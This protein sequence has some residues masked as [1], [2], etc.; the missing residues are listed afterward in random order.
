LIKAIK[1]LAG[2]WVIALA[3]TTSA[4]AQY[5]TGSNIPFGQNRVQYNE[6]YWQSFNFERF[7]VF[8]YADGKNHAI[9][10]AKSA[11]YNLKELEGLLDFELSDKIEIL[12]F[13]SQSQ[14][15]QSNI[16]LTNDNNTNIGGVTKII[17]SKIFVY[18]EGD[19]AT[20]DDQIRAGVSEVLLNQMMYGGSWKDVLKNNTLLSLPDW[21]LKG[22]ISYASKGWNTEIDNRVKDGILTD[23]FVNFNA[24]EGRDA[25]LAGHSIWNYIAEVY[26]EN[27]IPNVMYM[28]RVS[29]SVESGFLFVLGTPLK[30]LMNDY[31]NYYKRKYE[32]DEKFRNN[33]GG[34][35]IQIKTKKRYVY[36]D[37]SLSPDG[38]HASF[39]TN[40]RG[41]YKVWV[42]TIADKKMRRIHKGG[43]DLN[44]IV[45][46]TFPV[47]TWHPTSKVLTYFV[48]KKG[49]VVINIYSIE[50]KKTTRRPLLRLNKV[51][52]AEYSDD[53]KFIVLS[54]AKN[55]QTDLFL[56]KITGN[57][58][59]QLR[60][61]FTMTCIPVSLIIQPEL[62]FLP[63][64]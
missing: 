24:L 53:G 40:E 43:L 38:K 2:I 41:Q 36:S 52:H 45:D 22:F 61:I 35:E 34:E 31:Q 51:L 62:Y 28:T 57:S 7:K 20:F 3:L 13:N 64:D 60:M 4:H 48:E 27:V 1:Y 37:F 58:Q 25:E 6:F 47:L 9:Y 29:R 23:R 26:G 16:G 39:V 5:Y 55:G 59:K 21:Y 14:F 19:H 56:Y 15:Q 32:L 12:V 44:R 63:I 30:T 33:V 50:D 18:Y 11:H 54:A 42:Y 8:F 49:E 17:G 46:H 10:A